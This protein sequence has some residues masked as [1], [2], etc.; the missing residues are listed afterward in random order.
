MKPQVKSCASDSY[1][2]T[3]PSPIVDTLSASC[4]G[5]AM[6]EAPP[7][8]WFKRHFGNL[9]LT[10]YL[11][12]EGC[13]GYLD[14][15]EVWDQA[16]WIIVTAVLVFNV[17]RRLPPYS[18]DRSLKA[19]IFVFLSLSHIMFFEESEGAVTARFMLL[20]LLLLADG[21]LLYL[22]RSISLLPAR[23][24]IKTGFL[25]RAVRHPAYGLYI[26][27]DLLYLVAKPQPRNFLVAFIGIGSFVFRAH[28]E[29]RVLAEDPAYREYQEKTP[30]RFLP[31]IY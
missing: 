28:Y 6:D 3:K 30:W 15:D 2:P 25:Y 20:A 22:G 4:Y 21:C 17:L 7:D 11:I 14:A 18:E 23:R 12:V 19:W 8:S 29:E 9:L 16:W 31:G 27:G 10:T 26:I 24:E 5:S 1:C 13:R